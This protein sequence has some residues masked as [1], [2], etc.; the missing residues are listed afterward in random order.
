MFAQILL[1]NVD[2]M[3]LEDLRE[4]NR[5]EMLVNGLSTPE[6]PEEEQFVIEEKQKAEQA[7]EKPNPQ[8]E[9]LRAEAKRASAEAQKLE[10]DSLENMANIK[11]KTASA[12][13]K[14]AETAKIVAEIGFPVERP[15]FGRN[16][17]PLP[18]LPSQ[19][20][21]TGGQGVSAPFGAE[22]AIQELLKRGGANRP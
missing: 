8:E 10:T 19:S 21:P 11:D 12:G 4:M 1:A 2:G 9:Y 3:G 16:A 15:R 14:E 13:K 20:G 18:S 6:T 5:K 22:S 7:E 17:E